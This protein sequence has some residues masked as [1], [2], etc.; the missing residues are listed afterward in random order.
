[1]PKNNS[2]KKKDREIYTPEYLDTVVKAMYVLNNPEVYKEYL[3]R[4]KNIL[5]I[6]LMVNQN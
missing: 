3:K 1:M 6:K 2:N 5:T 4:D